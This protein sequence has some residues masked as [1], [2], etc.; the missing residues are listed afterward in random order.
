MRLYF[1]NL[2]KYNINLTLNIALTFESS[3]PFVNIC[4]RLNNDIANSYSVKTNDVTIINILNDV[5]KLLNNGNIEYST[6]VDKKIKLIIL[7]LV[8]RV[9]YCESINDHSIIDESTD[10]EIRKYKIL[11]YTKDNTYTYMSVHKGIFKRFEK[12]YKKHDIIKNIMFIISLIRDVSV[13]RLMHIGSSFH[14]C[15]IE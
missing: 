2:K 11:V 15:I 1:C 9:C 4:E 10:I 12:L 7:S 6:S 8:I 14:P 5:V 13:N 3:G